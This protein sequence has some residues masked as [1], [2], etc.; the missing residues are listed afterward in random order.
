MTVTMAATGMARLVFRQP[1]G[2]KERNVFGDGPFLCLEYPHPGSIQFVK[3]TA[4]NAANHDC[5]HLMSA[6][7]CHRIAG[8]VL[9]NPV[10]VVDGY[11]LAGYHV[12]HDKPRRRPE[13][14]MH[15][16]LQTIIVRLWEKNPRL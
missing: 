10:A 2:P 1:I 5:I 6:K 14:P 11:Y 9:V 15:L 16:T 13:M 7:T 12:N 3:R 4:A 8:P